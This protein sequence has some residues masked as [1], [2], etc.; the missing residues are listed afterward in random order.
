[1][2]RADGH[3]D[4][5]PVPPWSGRSSAGQGGR[6]AD[7]RPGAQLRGLE[8]R[9]QVRIRDRAA[10]AARPHR[11]RAP[12]PAAAGADAGVAG[13]RARAELI[14][15]RPSATSAAPVSLGW[16]T[17]GLRAHQAILA[18]AE[19]RL[20]QAC[21]R[22]IDKPDAVMGLALAAAGVERDGTRPFGQ[23]FFRPLAPDRPQAVHGLRIPRRKAHE[24]T[25]FLD[26]PRGIRHR[27]PGRQALERVERAIAPRAGFRRPGRIVPG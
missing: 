22:C 8:L 24:S 9:E 16:A 2:A 26:R 20:A 11:S 4:S 12:G 23:P 7:P 1:M 15:V 13:G 10:P 21:R 25:Q 3:G 5:R 18:E 6:R 27:R 14:C 17:L 19:T